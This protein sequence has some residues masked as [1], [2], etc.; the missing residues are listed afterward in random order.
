MH[1]LHKLALSDGDEGYLA[2]ALI[3][4]RQGS[5]VVPQLLHSLHVKL[6]LSTEFVPSTVESQQTRKASNSRQG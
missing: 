4:Q 3:C 2:T 5:H 1:P 6:L